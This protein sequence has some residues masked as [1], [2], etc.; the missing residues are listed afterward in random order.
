MKEGYATIFVDKVLVDPWNALNG[1]VV[2]A[3]AVD[4][5]NFAGL[6]LGVCWNALR[7]ELLRRYLFGRSSHSLVFLSFRRVFVRCG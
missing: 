6:V 1:G 7:L 2:R 5:L 4:D 3:D